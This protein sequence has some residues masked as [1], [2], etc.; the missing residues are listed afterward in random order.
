MDRIKNLMVIGYE[1]RDIILENVQE[2]NPNEHKDDI[3][4]EV[5]MRTS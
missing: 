1:D 3:K 4:E 2:C 5:S